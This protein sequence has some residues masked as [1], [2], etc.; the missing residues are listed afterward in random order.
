MVKKLSVSVPDELW[1]Q[2]QT[3]RP[4]LNPSHLVKAALETFTRPADTAG[5]SLAR[6]A[7]AEDDF[8]AARAKFADI[9]REGLQRGLPSRRRIDAQA[10]LVGHPEPGGSQFRR[11]G[12]G[13]GLREA[14]CRGRDWCHPRGLGARPRDRKSA[15]RRA[16]VLDHAVRRRSASTHRPIPSRI[17]PGLS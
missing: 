14:T 16:R 7:D 12:L 3:Q 6:P 15:R 11:E 2:A 13:R 10:R 17:R 5:F 1:E 8:A 9:A 4:D